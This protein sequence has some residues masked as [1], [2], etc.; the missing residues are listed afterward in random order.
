MPPP[1]HHERNRGLMVRLLTW[2]IGRKRGSVGWAWMDGLGQA[3][4]TLWISARG[5]SLSMD[6]SKYGLIRPR[7]SSADSG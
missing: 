6:F 1:S 2:R 4:K 3:S 7:P 5:E